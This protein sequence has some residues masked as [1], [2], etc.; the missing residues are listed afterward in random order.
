MEQATVFVLPSRVEPW[1]M[2]LTEAMGSALACITSNLPTLQEVVQHGTTGLLIEPGQP[3]SIAEALI[4]LLGNPEQAAAMGKAAYRYVLLHRT[5]A[6]AG[7]RIS[8][9]LERAARGEV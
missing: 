9:Y 8:P 6:H 4:E 7:A 3:D 5:W 1:G 2:V